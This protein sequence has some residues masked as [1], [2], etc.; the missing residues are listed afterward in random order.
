MRTLTQRELNR[1]LL[2]RQLLLARV[3]LNVPRAVGR[4][5]ALQAQYAPSPYMALWSRLDGFRKEQ[6]TRALERGTVVKATT[7]RGTLHVAAAPDFPFL[8]TAYIESRRGRSTNLG[9]DLGALRA[10]F[11]D[12][13]LT[14]KEVFE[15]AGQALGTDDRWTIAFALRALTF[16][17]T[18]PLGAWP[19]HAPSPAVIVRDP[20][21]SPEEGAARVVRAYL[22]AYG[23]ASRDDVEQFTGFRVRQIEPVLEGMR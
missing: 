16:V 4:L 20:L 2:A 17:R 5:V 11:P 19:H 13:P 14:G 6:L 3:K 15:L 7:I 21:P 8:Q 9:V 22:A 1:T 12:R 18:P 23:P 10:A